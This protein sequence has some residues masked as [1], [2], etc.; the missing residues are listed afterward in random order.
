MHADLSLYKFRGVHGVWLIEYSSVAMGSVRIDT[1]RKLGGDCKA[2][3]DPVEMM[4]A[5]V[6]PRVSGNPFCNGSWLRPLQ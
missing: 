5:L 2:I 1:V 6:L 4:L 3:C